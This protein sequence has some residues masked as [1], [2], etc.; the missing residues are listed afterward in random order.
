MHGLPLHLTAY[1]RLYLP[2][3]V[4][5]SAFTAGP[6]ATSGFDGLAPLGVSS[7]VAPLTLR[8]VGASSP[9]PNPAR[10]FA[11]SMLP[12][13]GF[14]T[15]VPRSPWYY[16]THGTAGD[17]DDRAKYGGQVAQPRLA[18]LIPSLNLQRSGWKTH[19]RCGHPNDAEGRE[20]VSSIGFGMLVPFSTRHAS[21]RSVSAFCRS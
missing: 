16:H 14:S 9:A 8:P 11:Q 17:G 15:C 6:A 12:E 18:P 2:H 21:R 19:R 20:A 10:I 1:P 5:A 3:L 4:G 13:S 7:S